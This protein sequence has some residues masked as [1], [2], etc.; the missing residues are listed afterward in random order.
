MGKKAGDGVGE[1]ETE[2]RS[3]EREDKAFGEEL[4]HE[5]QAACAE[6][7]AHGKLFAAGRGAC[8]QK[9]GEIDGDDQQDETDGAPEDHERAAQL[10]ADVIFETGNVDREIESTTRDWCCDERGEFLA[11]ISFC[12]AAGVTPGLSTAEDGEHVAPVAELAIES[13]GVKI[14]TFMPG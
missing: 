5:A 11:F 2:R 14:S 12:A 8:E 9:V 1:D 6:G 13:R 4:A 7:A 3:G 10:A